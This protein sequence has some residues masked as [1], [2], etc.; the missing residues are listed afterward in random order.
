MFAYLFGK[1][2]D[3]NQFI[4]ASIAS[5]M[6]DTITAAPMNQLHLKIAGISL[7]SLRRATTHHMVASIYNIVMMITGS[8]ILRI[9]PP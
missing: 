4:V 1:Q 7:P 3:Q 2:A 9:V 8:Q 5:P 6:K